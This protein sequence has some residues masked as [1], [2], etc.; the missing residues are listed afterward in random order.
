M[1]FEEARAAFPVLERFAFLNAGSNGPLAR[2]TVEAMLAE[3]LLDVARG[4]GGAPYFESVL[5]LREEARARLARVLGVEPERVALT[6]STTESCNIVLSGLGL[7]PDAEIVT[8]DEEHFGLLGALHASAARV[9]VAPAD[10]IV[11][12]VTERTRLIA[13][14][15][16]SWVTGKSLEPARVKA[17]TGLP[18]LVDGAQAVGAIPVEVG[19]L[20]FYAISCQKWL[21]GPDVTGALFIAEPDK[22]RV[23]LPSYLSQAE[24]GPDGSFVP[25]E[26]AARFD[27]GWLGAASLAGLVAAL[28]GAPEWRFERG[29]EIVGRCREALAERF[30]VVTKPGQS[31]L[32]SFRPAGD[33]EETVARLYAQDVVVRAIPGKDL[34]R[35]SCGYWTSEEDVERLLAGLAS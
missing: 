13:I 32:V 31:G 33:P 8:S 29:A 14:S 35:V 10:R 22:L 15:H 25:K 17:E 4:R 12:A 7:G 6:R 9:R 11:E 27:S 20:D 3:Q 16:V 23:A 18:V 2:A 34:I 24:Y 26:G 30:E 19:E 28:G 21:C 5:A 1:T